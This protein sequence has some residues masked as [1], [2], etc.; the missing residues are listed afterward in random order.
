MYVLF[1]R[2]SW[3]DNSE[4]YI[5]HKE[6]IGVYDSKKIM[7]IA[8]EKARNE[9][10]KHMQKMGFDPW[11]HNYRAHIFYEEYELNKI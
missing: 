8:I 5:E 3:F 4:E 1:F 6:V 7:H 10:N 9:R 2:E 11:Y